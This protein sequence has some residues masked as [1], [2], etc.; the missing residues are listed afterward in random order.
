MFTLL[1]TPNDL[2]TAR[3]GL[4]VSRKVSAR[5]VG[6]NRIKRQAR[7]SFRHICKDMPAID[8]VVM[9]KKAAATAT[10]ADLRNSLDR[11]WKKL[12]SKCVTS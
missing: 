2:P 10:S 9:A 5:A 11:H 8:I 7:E 3:L 12:A 6:R 4:T 1:A